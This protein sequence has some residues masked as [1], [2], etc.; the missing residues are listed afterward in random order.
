MFRVGSFEAY[1]RPWPRPQRPQTREY[2][3]SLKAAFPAALERVDSQPEASFRRFI[4]VATGGEVPAT[5]FLRGSKR[6]FETNAFLS[7]KRVPGV[8]RA[9]WHTLRGGVH[10]RFKFEEFEEFEELT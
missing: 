5:G 4:S 10:I 8:H 9:P 2:F 6:P 1:A 3:A 7:S